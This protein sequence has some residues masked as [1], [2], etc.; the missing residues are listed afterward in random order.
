MSRADVDCGIC[1][2]PGIEHAFGQCPKPEA[3]ET[4]PVEHATRTE[5]L[6][7]ALARCLDTLVR[8]IPEVTQACGLEPVTD[9][10]ADAAIDAAARVLHGEDVDQWPDHLRA[11]VDDEEL[12]EL[13]R[14]RSG[15]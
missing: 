14:R 10:E 12:L 1:G 9:D 5:R 13:Q 4:E 11:A 3:V 7:A 15:R 6:E 2:R 8:E